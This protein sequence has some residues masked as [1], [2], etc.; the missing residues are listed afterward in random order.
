MLILGFIAFVLTGI[1]L[2]INH[3]KGW[4][5]VCFFLALVMVAAM[6]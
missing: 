3:H 5:I 1:G 6:L 2:C 4:G